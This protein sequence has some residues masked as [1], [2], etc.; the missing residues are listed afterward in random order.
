MTL[1]TTQ[2]VA[3][4]LK[5]AP[6]TV[7]K[8]GINAVRIGEGQRPRYR[9]RQEDVDNYIQSH[10]EIKRVTYGNRK[11]RRQKRAAVSVSGLPTWED[12]KRAVA[13]NDRGGPGG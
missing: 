9:Y 8:I 4:L 11:A 10:L 1:L 7:K 12:A 6:K 5:V 2:E 13:G 3:D